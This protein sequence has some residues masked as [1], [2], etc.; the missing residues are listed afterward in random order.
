MATYVMR[1]G[2]LVPIE[3]AEPLFEVYGEAPFVISDSMTSTKHMCDGKFYDSKAKFREVTKAHGCIEVGNDTSHMKPR[4]PVPLSREKR[5]HD[6]KQAIEKL[7]QDGR[8]K[9]RRRS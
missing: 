5:V 6:I 4:R 7:K 8:R 9:R 1:K 2:Q 3:Q